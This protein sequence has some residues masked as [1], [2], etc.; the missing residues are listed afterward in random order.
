M[1]A[2]PSGIGRAGIRCFLIAT[3]A[4]AR[5]P[6]NETETVELA[7]TLAIGVFLAIAVLVVASILCKLLLVAGLVPERRNSRLRRAIVWLAA[8]VGQVRT[9]EGRRDPVSGRRSPGGGGGSSGGA[10]ASGDF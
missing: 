6:E 1:Y 9:V 7:T 5:A 8:V 10:G 3:P 2:A 4:F